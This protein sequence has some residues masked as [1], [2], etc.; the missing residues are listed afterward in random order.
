ME[1]NYYNIF[2]KLNKI[3]MAAKAKLLLIFK[4]FLNNF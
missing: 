3:N 1:E 4:A 2:N